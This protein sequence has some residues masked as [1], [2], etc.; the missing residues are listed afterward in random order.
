[1]S[2][3]T[4]TEPELTLLQ[5]RL[6]ASPT[7][8]F[9]QKEATSLIASA[10]AQVGV[11]IPAAELLDTLVERQ[12]IEK[13]ILTSDRYDS[14]VRYGIPGASIFETA[15]SLKPAAYLSHG[16]AVF[17]HHL[18]LQLPRVIYVNKEQSVKPAPDGQL[19]QESIDRAFANQQRESKYVLEWNDWRIVLLSGKNT[20]NLEVDLQLADGAH[21]P[22][23]KLERTLIDIAVRPNYAGGVYQ[24]L[25]AYRSARERVSVNVLIAT[26]RKMAY[27]YPYHQVI[28]L[29][30]Q[31]AGYEESRISRLRSFGMN[32][33]FYL[34][35]GLTDPDF[36]SEWRVFIPKDF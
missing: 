35:Y 16:T 15:A 8:V 9:G 23:T 28:G 32:F 10:K 29:Y 4:L 1:M 14:F 7:R 17:L 33:N 27:V 2:P 25:E 13:R 34:T 6:H 12:V 22:T 24:V 36:D 30:M 19:S 5:E 26:L 3:R 31:R 11:D 20:G 21:V 18:G